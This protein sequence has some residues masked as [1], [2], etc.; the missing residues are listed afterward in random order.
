MAQWLDRLS[1]QASAPVIATSG[2]TSPQPQ[3][4]PYSP[5]PR[6][7]TGGLEPYLTSQRP[8]LGGR[9]PSSSISLV[10]NEPSG[11]LLAVNRPATGGSPL[12][13]TSTLL[14]AHPDSSG[15]SYLG[16]I[17]DVLGTDAALPEFPELV[18]SNDLELDFAFEGLSLRALAQPRR[19]TTWQQ[20]SGCPPCHMF[21]SH[22][23]T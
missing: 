3:S 14:G 9:S 12:K 4:R 2:T 19:R 15:D 20:D 10:S 5:I 11:S 16:A 1:S 23:L 7:P 22:E 21:R 13:P 6:R 18:T 8:G 17:T